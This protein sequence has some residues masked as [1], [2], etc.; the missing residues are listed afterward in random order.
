VDTSAAG[1]RA[2]H[3]AAQVRAGT[4]SP[5]DVVRDHLARIA[6]LD[7]RVGAFRVVRGAA[8][9]AEAAGVAVRA[10]LADLPLAGV[11]V[12]IKDNVDVAGET[13]RRGSA[14]TP[15]RPAHADD[16]LVRRLR[17]AGCVVVGK[18]NLP[19]L[20][21]WGF[22]ESTFGVARNPHDTDRNAGGSTGGGAAAVAAGFAPLALG[23]D[24]GGSIRIPSAYCGVFGL[25]PGRGV[26]PNAGGGAPHWY[27]LSA[28]GPIA[29][30]AEDAA[31]MFDVLAGRGA[32]ADEPG[33]DGPVP[34]H[35]RAGQSGAG[36][37]GA[38]QSGAGQS[39]AGQSGA[40]QSGA[41]QAGAGRARGAWPL[42]IA[43]SRRSP[44]AL[45]RPDAHALAGLELARRRLREA[46]HALAET[47]PRYPA[48]LPFTFSA[49]WFA[50]IAEDA[51]DLPFA[52]LEP[53]TR[54]IVRL[55]R[56]LERR[57]GPPG[58]GADAWTE[59][60]IAFFEAGGFD[61]LVT[62]SVAGPA[63]RAGAMSGRGFA[64]TLTRSARSVPYT[65]AWN[66]AGLPA[67]SVPVGT[68]DGMPLAA[69]LVGPPGSEDVLL[70]LAASLEDPH[71]AAL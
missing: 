13:T 29:A 14:A 66:V 62:P 70:R 17:A 37:S 61:V 71:L 9:L 39:G 69:Q 38:G 64:R 28:F 41:G 19:E 15:D 31:I 63:P 4:L 22:T 54:T 59:T 45:M 3:I 55:G 10:D 56:P 50:G 30:D 18:T 16:E 65:Q 1:M 32:R 57:G 53:R 26:V 25:K 34:D 52:Q 7:G 21:I 23:S 60:A 44:S 67:A 27:G 36:Q 58:R 33:S 46:G 49:F 42:R 11:P 40:G 12:A 24:G 8:A 20:A 6:A 47:G 43:V 5:V 35:P 48:R 2:R 51:R 68:R